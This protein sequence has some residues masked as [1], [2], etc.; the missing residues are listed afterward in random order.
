MTEEKSESRKKRQMELRKERYR[1][2]KTSGICTMC[3]K[4]PAKADAFI[5]EECS[6]K[7]RDDREYFKEMGICPI[8][9]KNETYG[10]YSMC[11][12]CRC[13]QLEWNE[14]HRTVNRTG[15]R[16]YQLMHYANCKKMGI[17]PS[18][19]RRAA[20]G[21]VRCR[22]CLEKNREKAFLKRKEHE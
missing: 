18:C 3:G 2:R 11:I 21:K 12:E 5:C 13:R 20:P 15:A 7:R 22:I 8:C 6:A 4:N 1:M 16:E 14:K 10:D 17:C 9:R 19:G